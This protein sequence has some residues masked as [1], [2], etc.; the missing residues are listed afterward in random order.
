MPEYLLLVDDIKHWKTDYPRFPVAAVRDYLTGSDWAK[1][2]NLHVINLCR[3]LNYH[4]LGYYASLLAEARG[5]RMLP[6]VKTL[7]DLTRKTLYG[8]IIDD[9]DDVVT[10]ALAK[11]AQHQNVD[12]ARF[13]IVLHFGK[14]DSEALRPLARRLYE[15]FPT[16]LLRVEF[17]RNGRWRI[18]KLKTGSLTTLS[19]LQE[20]YFFK[21]L[22]NKLQ[23]RWREPDQ[24]IPARYNLAILHDPQEALPPS[25]AKALHYFIKAAAD[26]GIETE[27]ITGKDIGHIAEYDALFIRETTALNNHTYRFARKA[28]NE[29]L[30]VIDDPSSILRCV[31]K[32]YLSELLT[33]NKIQIPPSVI[34]GKGELERAEKKLGYPM[35]LKIPDGSFSRGMFKVKDRSELEK[36]AAEL[37]EHSELILA[38]AYTYTE[39]DWRIGI[40]NG[41][42]IYACRYYM[43]RGHWQIINHNKNGKSVEGR[44]DTLAID[45]VPVAV[46]ETA[47]KAARLIGDGLYGVDLKETAQGVVVIEVNDNPSIEHGVEDR[48]L[49]KQLY[50]RIMAEFLRRLDAKHHPSKTKKTLKPSIEV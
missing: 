11:Q 14:C 17:S 44:A 31:N 40:L 49:G 19:S 37:F 7:H 23:Q 8:P 13:E 45:Q 9:L 30:V 18:S 50:Q 6:S 1:K 36:A 20:G 32:I 48:V 4:S 33:A 3:N 24:A 41:E 10:K 35:V 39:F 22:E 5:H 43:S 47:L 29:G 2:R 25:D 12:I 42:A 15:A 46:L 27:F 38:Q 34:L 26:L 21:V 16:P 28:A